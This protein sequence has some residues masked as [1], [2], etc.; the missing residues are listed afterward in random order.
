MKGTEY[1]RASTPPRAYRLSMDEDD[2]YFSGY[3][4]KDVIDS[5]LELNSSVVVNSEGDFSMRLLPNKND[6]TMTKLG[7]ETSFDQSTLI[8]GL[9]ETVKYLDKKISNLE[10]K[11]QESKYE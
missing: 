6:L 3:T 11:G 4:Q 5:I 1:Q 9:V 10:N 2:L 7:D 8:A